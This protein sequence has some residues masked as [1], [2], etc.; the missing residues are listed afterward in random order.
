M[1]WELFWALFT[2]LP[3]AVFA[4]A[5]SIALKTRQPTYSSTI[6]KWLGIK[7]YNHRRRITVRA[8]ILIYLYFSIWFVP[9][10][11]WDLW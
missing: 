6:R 5:E 4:I 9:H 8:F 10:I 11:V 1:T 7:P 3:L 2:V